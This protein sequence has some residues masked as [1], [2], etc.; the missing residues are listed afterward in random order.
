METADMG[1][2]AGAGAP[3]GRY[4]GIRAAGRAQSLPGN[5][6]QP[7]GGV[8]HGA[9]CPR[10]RAV[11]SLGVLERHVHRRGR[12][13]SL[14]LCQPGGCAI[15]RRGC[16]RGCCCDRVSGNAYLLQYGAGA[17]LASLPALAL[18]ALAPRQFYYSNIVYIRLNT[19]Y[20]EAILHR[21][22]MDLASKLER[23][24][25]RAAGPTDSS[26]AV[27]VLL[28]TVIAALLRARQ[29]REKPDVARLTIAAMAVTLWMTAFAPTP[30][31]LQYMSA[32]LPF[33]L[34]LLGASR[35]PTTAV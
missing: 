25:F 33:L 16:C 23:L 31:L 30:M 27:C 21:T 26:P 14:Q 8:L 2:R 13:N 12:P 20:Y 7:G 19:V 29:R 1:I 9:R 34:I 10:R 11:R 15:R 18:A 28:L 4:R 17:L 5:V 6:L 22:G 32:P 3:A 24:W 35:G